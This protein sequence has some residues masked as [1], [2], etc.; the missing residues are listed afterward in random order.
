MLDFAALSQWQIRVW[1]NE[2]H[3]TAGDGFGIRE[4][5]AR[6]FRDVGF[7]VCVVRGKPGSWVMPR[8]RF[9]ELN[10]EVDRAVFR[11]LRRSRTRRSRSS[12][13]SR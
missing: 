2:S 7:G 10:S 1:V 5:R 8:G 11:R 13:G 3:G 4:R 9:A 6:F 12:G